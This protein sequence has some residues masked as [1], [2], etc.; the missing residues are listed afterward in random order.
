MATS[1]VHFVRLLIEVVVVNVKVFDFV[2]TAHITSHTNTH[3]THT[4]HTSHTHHTTHHTQEESTAM[5]MNLQNHRSHIQ[6]KR[7]KYFASVFAF[8]SGEPCLFTNLRLWG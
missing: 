5:M 1:Q 4:L 8:A 2:L 6:N 7:E 3:I